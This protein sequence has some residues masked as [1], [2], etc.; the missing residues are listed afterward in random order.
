VLNDS[1]E[2]TWNACGHTNV[3]VK[4]L[5]LLDLGRIFL[6]KAGLVGALLHGRHFG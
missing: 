6:L 1:G 4:R 3:K 5:T 2:T